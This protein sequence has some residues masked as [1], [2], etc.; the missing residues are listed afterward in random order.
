MNFSFLIRGSHPCDP[1]PQLPCSQLGQIYTTKRPKQK[2]QVKKPN[3]DVIIFYLQLENIKY[4]KNI[5][6]YRRWYSRESKES[7]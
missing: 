3:T 1:A 6:A 2:I 5:G 4:N 7:K